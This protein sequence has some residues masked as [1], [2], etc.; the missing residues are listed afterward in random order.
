MSRFRTIANRRSCSEVAVELVDKQMVAIERKS[1]P[2]EAS[3][4]ING[5]RWANPSWATT[6]FIWV[7][8]K[9]HIW[10]F[11]RERMEKNEKETK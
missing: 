11:V 5:R 9:D 10:R 4:N 3:K 6:L 2:R 7:E 1:E 8:R